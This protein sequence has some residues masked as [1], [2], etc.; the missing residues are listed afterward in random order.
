MPC[1]SEAPKT[2]AEIVGGYR[3]R[4]AVI[5]KTVEGGRW[6]ATGL[7]GMRAA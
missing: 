2:D 6:Y 3:D 1:S 5:D 7:L 4:D